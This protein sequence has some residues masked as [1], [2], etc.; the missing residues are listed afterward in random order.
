M[1]VV[2]LILALT[3][4]SAGA[5]AQDITQ[6]CGSHPGLLGDD[7]GSAVWFSSSQLQG[8]TLKPIMPAPVQ[9]Q[10]LDLQGSGETQDHGKHGRRCDL[11]LGREGPYA[12]AGK[13]GQ[14]GPRLEVQAQERDGRLI[15]VV[16]T[17]EIPVSANGN[18]L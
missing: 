17:L 16:G 14:S 4:F 9:S 1:R 6:E 11:Y 18:G 7:S 5:A 2:A 13:C 8:M 12:D 15:E 10:G 3:L